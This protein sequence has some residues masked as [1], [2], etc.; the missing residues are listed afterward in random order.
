VALFGQWADILRVLGR[1]LDSSDAQDIEIKNED[2]LAVRWR[3]ASGSTESASYTEFDMNKL[4]EQA[5]LMRRPVATPPKTDR[6]EMLRTIGQEM[7]EQAITV[8]EIV[9]AAGA[10]RVYGS[11]ATG[12]VYRFYS[13]AEL[14]GLSE[15][16]RAMRKPVEQEPTTSDDGDDHPTGEH[17]AAELQAPATD[18]QH[19]TAER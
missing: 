8:R 5:P 2:R 7:D 15:K 17:S 19:G 16:R 1:F 12:E 13:R 4:R 11:D 3:M 18:S 10:Y 6:E 14:R 9:E